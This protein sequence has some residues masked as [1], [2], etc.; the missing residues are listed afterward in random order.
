M[1]RRAAAT[2]AAIAALPATDTIKES[3]ARALVVRTLDRSCLWHAQTPQIFR[4]EII[5]DAYR[6]VRRRGATATDDAQIAEMAG[7]PVTIVRG[8]PNNVKI[9]TTADIRPPGRRI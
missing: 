7:F 4:R 3:S 2:G 9:T 1:I 6:L 5:V 8:S